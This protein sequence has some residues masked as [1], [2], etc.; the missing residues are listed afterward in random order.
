MIRIGIIGC[1]WAGQ[2]H[3]EAVASA[4]DAKVSAIADIDEDRLKKTR[5]NWGVE[6]TF[7]DY[8]DMLDTELIDA[9]VIALPHDLHREAAVLSAEA[10]L[11]ILCEKPITISVRDADA[12]IDSAK[13]NDVTLMVAESNRYDNLTEKIENLLKDKRIGTPVFATWNDLHKFKRWRYEDRPWLNDPK[14]AGGGHWIGRGIHL[15]SPLRAWFRTGGAGD[16]DKVFVKEYRSPSFETPPGIEG[17]ISAFL[18]FDGGQTARINM[19]VEVQHYDRFNDIRIHG[20]GGSLVA[21]S[22]NYTID[23]YSGEDDHPEIIEL[24]RESSFKKE[25]KHFLSCI[26][27]NTEPKTSGIEERNSLA[28]IEAGYRSMREDQAIKVEMREN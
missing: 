5:E 4:S 13:R 15:V 1:G 6:H 16:V 11:H 9:V 24:K 10:G 19:G 14:R 18:A 23:I 26:N 22:K 3:Y 7:K 20:T 25:M 2:R 8:R 28:V 12:M 27:N 17:N 21:S